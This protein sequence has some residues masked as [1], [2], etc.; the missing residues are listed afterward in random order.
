MLLFFSGFSRISSKIAKKQVENIKL[1]DIFLNKMMENVKLAIDILQSNK[2]LKEFGQLLHEN[3]LL[4]KNLASNISTNEIDS[5]YNTAV[6]SGAIGGK[7]LGAGGGVSSFF[8]LKNR[9]KKRLF[10]L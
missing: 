2:P 10:K 9:I 4:K 1:N 6:N 5:M 8:M 7:V 3:W